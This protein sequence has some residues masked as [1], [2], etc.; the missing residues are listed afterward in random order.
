MATRRYYFM[1]Q[2]I[3]PIKILM[4]D[5]ELSDDWNAAVSA[6]VKSTLTNTI[7]E[8]GSYA[9]AIDNNTDVFTEKNMNEVPEL[10]ELFEMFVDSFYELSQEYENE[11]DGVLTKEL[12]RECLSLD[13]GKL[14]IM[15]YKQSRRV[16]NHKSASAFGIFYLSDVDNEADGGQLV[17]H[18][19][20]F[21]TQRFFCDDRMLEIDT[22]KHRMVIAPNTV[23]HEVTTYF[24]HTERLTIVLNLHLP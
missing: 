19:P 10:R 17:L 6:F 20:T 22:K 15:R 3:F 13:I 4:K 9:A 1:I 8:K 5:Y 11:D 23:W 2:T 14:P 18:D 16:H 24:G 7:T 21:N 12:I